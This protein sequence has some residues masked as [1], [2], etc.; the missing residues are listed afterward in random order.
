VYQNIE[1]INNFLS[2][3]HNQL[4]LI[5][6]ISDEIGL[7]YINVINHFA[8][9]N[10]IK[11]SFVNDLKEM[12]NSNDLFGLKR[13]FVLNTS[14]KKNVERIIVGDNKV[15]T[16]TDYKVLR[17]YKSK[18][19]SISGYDYIKDIKYFLEEILK[20]NNKN[21]IENIIRNPELT[22]S[23]ISKYLL[24][25][26]GYIKNISLRDDTNFILEIRKDIYKLKKTNDIKNIYFKIKD[27]AKYKKFSFLTY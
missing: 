11:I 14:N 24:S 20:L 17:E 7:F 21:L 26:S 23:E 15:I 12:T 4:L 5:S 10:N 8:Q 25:D 6:R 18:I 27:E 13:L 9:K 3:E 16:F 1:I 19:E 2:Q 22:Y